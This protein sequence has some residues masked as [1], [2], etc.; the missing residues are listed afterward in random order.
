MVF[1]N[2]DLVLIK[3]LRQEK[4]LRQLMNNHTAL[5]EITVNVHESVLSRKLVLDE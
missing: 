2:E 1:S 3:V 5:L 4:G